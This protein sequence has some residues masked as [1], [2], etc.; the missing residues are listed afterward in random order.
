MMVT[1]LTGLAGATAFLILMLVWTL[2]WALAVRAHAKSEAY[3][4]FAASFRAIVPVC[5]I[6]DAQR[7]RMEARKGY[8]RLA[9]VD[10]VIRDGLRDALAD[11]DR[12][13]ANLA[14]AVN[15]SPVIIGKEWHE[16]M[17]GMTRDSHGRLQ[18]TF[19][20]EWK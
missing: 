13:W 14:E 17:G 11:A 7:R 5:G 16:G 1:M 15:T 12:H 2:L 10:P 18:M 19:P 20:V 9:L 6:R 4:E 8:M 3:M